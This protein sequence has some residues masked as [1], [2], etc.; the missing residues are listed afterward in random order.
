MFYEC[1]HSEILQMLM[2]AHLH[3]ALMEGHATI[4]MVL[5]NVNVSTVTLVR[6]VERVSSHEKYNKLQKLLS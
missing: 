5:M 3:R 2:S 1:E 4:S 6:N